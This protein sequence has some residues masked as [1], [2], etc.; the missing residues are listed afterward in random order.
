M[1]PPFTLS[2]TS[3]GAHTQYLFPSL[4]DSTPHKPFYVTGSQMKSEP[5][6]DVYFTFLPIKESLLPIKTQALNGCFLT[7]KVI[8]HSHASI[9]KNTFISSGKST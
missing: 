7:E 3:E 9:S 4:V 1:L 8:K 2:H 6:L 5:I